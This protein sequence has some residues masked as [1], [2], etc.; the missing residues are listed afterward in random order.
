MRH[1][2]IIDA[3]TLL[4]RQLNPVYTELAKKYFRNKTV[5]VTGAGGSIGSEI[6]NQ[7]INLNAAKVI[8]LDR[9]EYA[10]YNLELKVYGSALLTRDN[11]VLADITDR[12]SMNR[13]MSEYRPDVVFHAAAVKHLPL[14]ERSPEIAFRTNVIGTKNVIESATHVGVRKIVN[15]STDKAADPTSVLGY[16]KRLA[17]MIASHFSTGST[18]VAS[19][20]FGNVFASRGSFIETLQWQIANNKDLTVTDADVTRFFMSIPQAAGLVIETT[21]IAESGNTYVLDMGDPVKIMD[22]IKRYC[23]ITQVQLPKIT[24]SGLRKGEK[25]HEVLYDL[26][27]NH[28]STAHDKIYTVRVQNRDISIIEDIDNLFHSI[29][30][31]DLNPDEVKDAI[32][33]LTVDFDDPLLKTSV[34]RKITDS[35]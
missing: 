11:L 32:K 6:V 19:V 13:I 15:I 34:K 7:L 5:L 9:D 31:E 35:L 21:V 20:R 4:G 12:R 8:C 30:L 10:L 26:R 22:L 3:E 29:S 1:Y 17:E 2:P 23:E 24:F 14:L 28:S 33:L 18:M 25:L 16:T 27:E